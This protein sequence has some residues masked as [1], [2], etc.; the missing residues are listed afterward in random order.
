MSY[1]QTSSGSHAWSVACRKPVRA[2]KDAAAERNLKPERTVA[3]IASAVSEL[4]DVVSRGRV[5]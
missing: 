4:D 2:E 1:S 5:F 3:R